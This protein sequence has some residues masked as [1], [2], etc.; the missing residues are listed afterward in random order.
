MKFNSLEVLVTSGCILF[1]IAVRQIFTFIKRETTRI[2]D[3]LKAL[4]GRS[5]ILDTTEK[6]D[7]LVIKPRKE[8]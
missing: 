6:K 1:T 8:V 2:M 4:D 7:I 5:V 3:N